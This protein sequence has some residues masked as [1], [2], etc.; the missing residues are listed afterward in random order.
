MTDNENHHTTNTVHGTPEALVQAKTVY[1]GVHIVSGVARTAPVPRQLPLPTTGFVDRGT[2]LRRL[3]ALV[4][5]AETGVPVAILAGSPGVGKTALAVHWA[6]RV[7][8]RFPDGDLYISMHGHAPGP[9]VEASQALDALLR[10]FGIASDRIPLDLDGR[11]ALYRSEV[12]GK[13]LLIVIDDVLAPAQVRPLL[14]ASS[15][16]MVVVTSRSTLPGLVAREG[17][18]RLPLGV[19]PLADSVDLLRGTVGTRVESEAHAAHELVEHCARLPLALRVAAERL[20]DRPDAALSDLVGELAAEESRLDAFA[21]EDELSDLRAVMA[22][23]YQALDEDTARFF[24]RLGLHPGPEFSP[25]A[26]AALTGASGT[27]ARRLLDRLTRTN[28]VERP[29]A[30]RYRLHDL[31]RLYAVERVG[32]EEGEEA[33]GEAVGRVARW[34]AHSAA[35]AQLAEHPNFPVVPGNGRPE[36]LPVFA[37]VDEAQAWFEAERANLV[38]VTEAALDHD[39]HDTTWRLPATTYPLFELHRHW[40][41]WRDLHAIGLRAAENAENSFGLARNHL[42]MGDAQWLL[43]DLAEAAHHYR[44]ALDANGKVRDPWVEGFALRQLGVVSWER[45]ERG[46][47]AAGFVERAI[48]VFRRAGER[49]GEA[50]GLLSLADF[51]TD[52]GRWEEALDHCRTAIGAFEGISDAWSAAWAGCTLGRILVGMGRAAEAVA[53]YQVAIAVF[54]A[55]NDADSRAVALLDLGEAHFGLNDVDRARQAWGAALDYFRDH[56]DPRAPEVVKRL[57]DLE[58]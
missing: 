19:L 27:E 4:Q 48:E 34:Y 51:D 33:A 44:A 40:H 21:E 29:R 47:D 55:R 22:T 17:A 23:S 36:E 14:P 18:E 50:M 53:E 41:Q 8:T 26:A 57:R 30:G 28:L 13:R 10:T 16:C 52:V 49:R 25:E 46:D 3:D 32:A 31:V 11:S 43:G 15:G 9:R 37:S 1:G 39:H 2:P 5:K 7:R 58:A 6:H 56:E 24:R 12:D 54:E 45:G 35:R 20:I 38:A 42:G